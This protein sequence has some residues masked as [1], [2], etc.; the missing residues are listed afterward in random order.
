VVSEAPDAGGDR[1]HRV[2]GQLRPPVGGIGSRWGA[3]SGRWGV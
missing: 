2:P 1:L 3:A